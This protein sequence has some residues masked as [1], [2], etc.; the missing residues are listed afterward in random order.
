MPRR[1]R[2]LSTPRLQLVPLDPT[3][4]LLQLEDVVAFFAALGVRVCPAWPPPLYDR[5]AMAHAAD[6]LRENPASVGWHSWVFIG[7]DPPLDPSL[8]DRVLIGAGGFHGPPDRDGVVEIGYAILPEHHR[9]GYA[10]EAAAAMVAWALRQRGVRAVRGRTLLDGHASQ[11]VLLKL[12]FAPMPD[13][14]ANV[15]AF[16]RKRARLRL[17]SPMLIRLRREGP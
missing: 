3:L 4:A 14:N 12:G 10:S 17:P 11:R 2:P 5:E 13:P 9:L 7:T 8:T 15:R 1:L 16:L 6:R